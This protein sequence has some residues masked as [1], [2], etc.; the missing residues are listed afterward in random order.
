MGG[1]PSINI[2]LTDVCPNRCRYCFATG[3]SSTE[4]SQQDPFMS[5]ERFLLVLDFLRKS[6]SK[7]IRLLGGEPLIHP[8]IEEFLEK[9]KEEQ[10]FE[11]VVIF[12]GGIF[13]RKVIRC[14]VEDRTSLVVNCNHPKDYDGP[15]YLQL[16]S[17]LGEMASH[18]VRITIGYNIYE[19]YFDFYPVLELCSTFAVDRLRIC[20]ANPNP[21]RST[22]LLDW[23]KRKEVG[24]R[25]YELIMA[26]VDRHF[27]V[28]LDCLVAPCAFSDSEWGEITK[29]LPSFA[30][31]YGVC[32]PALDVDQNLYVFR[33]FAYGNGPTVKLL[34]FNS[35]QDLYNYFCEEYDQYKW[36]VGDKQCQS[37]KYFDLGVCQGDCLAFRYEAIETLRGKH[38]LSK[39]ILADAYMQLHACNLDAAVAK[40]EEALEL[41]GHD[42]NVVSD[43]VFTLLKMSQRN[44]A[45]S[46]LDRYL[47]EQ[48]PIESS[49]VLMIRG[50]LAEMQ[51]DKKKALVF[52][53]RAL[54]SVNKEK[55]EEL[56]ARIRNLEA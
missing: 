1:N 33:C 25:I 7:E 37:C 14:L 34:D 41:Y 29:Y 38:K 35:T 42:G 43:Y 55:K 16:L 13:P 15:Q 17:N 18:G 49:P 28:V 40:F 36:Y 47:P 48:G 52:Y 20:V 6:N 50:L 45:L 32:G 11:H 4:E 46:A 24:H 51:G 9:V 31:G 56:C 8:Y 39:S 27:D 12:T 3:R 54:R 2:I 5:R 30:R 22:E 44:K 21:F 26:C 10:F 23:E 19:E 53:R